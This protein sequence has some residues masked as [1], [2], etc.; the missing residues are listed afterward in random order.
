MLKAIL[1]DD[2]P[3]CLKVLEWELQN[4]CPDVEVL[5]M[6]D[7]GKEGLKAL[8]Q[9]QPDVVFLDVDMPYMNGFEM[10]ELVPDIDFEVIFTTAHDEYAVKAF[11]IN[12]IDYL[13][14]PIDEDELQA[15]IK[16]VKDKK[17][18]KSGKATIAADDP[19]K[20]II[21]KIALPTFEGLVFVE[22]DQI[23][24]CQSD[25]NYTKI[26][27]KQGKDLFISK[28]L[29]ELEELLGNYHF[30]RVHNS[31]VVN[32]NEIKNYVKADGGYLVMVNDDK[33]RVSRSK[34]ESLLSMFQTPSKN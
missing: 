4:S 22:V 16:K 8:Q 10:L 17:Q 15:A 3:N 11:K 32:L 30:Y 28:T 9:H 13:L 1:I 23:I 20:N 18:N 6:F 21:R 26:F 33:V 29:K 24:Y 25:N 31:F 12:A 34:K 14:K 2:E 7:S 27:L 19:R 5:G